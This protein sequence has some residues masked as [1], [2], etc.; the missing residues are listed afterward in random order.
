MRKKTSPREE[1]TAS[2][3]ENKTGD[4]LGKKPKEAKG[5]LSK[6]IE[7]LMKQQLLFKHV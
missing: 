4:K 6:E 7:M 1:D 5:T 2:Q 3:I